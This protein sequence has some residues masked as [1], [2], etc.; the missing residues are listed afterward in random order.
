ME[1]EQSS[2]AQMQQLVDVLVQKAWTP[3]WQEVGSSSLVLQRGFL[4]ISPLMPGMQL[5]SGEPVQFPYPLDALDWS[6]ERLDS[7]NEHGRIE[8]TQARWSRHES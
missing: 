8:E 7:L 3:G 6:G 5:T 2:D 1:L 4:E